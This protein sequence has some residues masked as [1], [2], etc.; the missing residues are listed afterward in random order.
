MSWLVLG[1]SLW[2]LWTYHAVAWEMGGVIPMT[3]GWFSTK[4][5]F[6]TELDCM[7]KAHLL[8]VIADCWLAGDSPDDVAKLDRGEVK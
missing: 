1:T 3:P 7:L 6:K 5:V 8:P 2:V 4:H